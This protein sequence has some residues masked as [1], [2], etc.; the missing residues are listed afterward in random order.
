MVMKSGSM[1]KKIATERIGIL[2]RLAKEA[3]DSDPEL[4]ARYLKIIKQISSHYRVK[5]DKTIRNSICKKCG[6]LLVPGKNL[7]VRLVSSKKQV[8]YKCLDCGYQ[9][10]IHY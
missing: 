3:R 10:R 8:L 4:A 9:R 5:L 6:S 7:S 1:V 2:Y